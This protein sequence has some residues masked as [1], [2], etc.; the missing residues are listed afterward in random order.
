MPTERGTYTFVVKEGEQ[1]RLFIA[2]E[3]YRETLPS[4]KGLLCFD[5]RD[6]LTIEQAHEIAKIMRANI[7]S[8][9]LTK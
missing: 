2:A 8:L 9:S 1:G 7:Q 6:G 5:L 3:P 4:V